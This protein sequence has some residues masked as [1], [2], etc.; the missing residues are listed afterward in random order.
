M[1]VISNY[2]RIKESTNSKLRC[3]KN[4]MIRDLDFIIRAIKF[5]TTTS[6][7]ITAVHNLE[8][9]Q[10]LR[11]EKIPSELWFYDVTSNFTDWNRKN[12]ESYRACCSYWFVAALF[13][14]LWRIWS[15]FQR[16]WECNFLLNLNE[17]PTDI[18]FLLENW[19]VLCVLLK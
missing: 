15:A 1:Y 14:A 17:I 19:R 3:K 5:R 4:D 11:E 18:I 12:R 2:T 7:N 10:I 16:F 6:R 8:G 9:R 13:L